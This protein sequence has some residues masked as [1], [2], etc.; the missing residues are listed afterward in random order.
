MGLE[1]RC[2][3]TIDGTQTEGRALL[4][5]DEIIFRGDEGTR[6]KIPFKQIQSLDAGDGELRITHA[7]GTATFA[8]GAKAATW[9]EK[10]RNP[11]SLL[12]KLGVKPSMRVAVIDV[13]DDA[14]VHDFA[15]RAEI[16][17]A[18]AG[19]LDMVFLGVASADDMARLA[20]LRVA[21][22]RDGAVWVVYRKG[23]KT[24]GENDVLRLGL[25]SGLFDVK[26]VRFS[27]THTA[28]KF[29]IRKS[30]R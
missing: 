6:L 22:K 8:L 14:F 20:P 16:V 7:A 2:A 17:D 28:T 1:L 5:T 19:D 15:G 21:I 23:Q 9:A 3:A 24:F 30:E 27:E 11:K 25:E 10:I 26:V 4:E 12:D 29:V 18:T 13:A